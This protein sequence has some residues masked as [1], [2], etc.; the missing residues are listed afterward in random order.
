MTSRIAGLAAGVL[1]V[2]ALLWGLFSHHWVIGKEFGIESHVG[3]RAIELC[4]EV[5]PDPA[6][7]GERV[8]T[9][10][11][12]GDILGTPSAIDGFKTFTQ[13]GAATFY[14]GL[15]CAAV[16]LL[17]MVLA[18]L[19]R[20][21]DLPI[22]PSTLAI[23]LAAGTIVLIALTLSLHPWKGVGWGTGS[24]ILLA[25]AGATACLLAGI[26]LGKLRPAVEDD[27]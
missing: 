4:Q 8:C 11:S 7:P 22:A 12:H 13:L 16:L 27:W 10:V 17:V 25:G 24:S 2:A 1:G 14:A 5:Q 23:V 20:H 18:A 26:L 9:A 15:A 6:Q 19:G 21:P 3:L